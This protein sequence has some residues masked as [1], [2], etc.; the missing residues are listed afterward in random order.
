VSDWLDSQ[1]KS[2]GNFRKLLQ[3]RIKKANTRR[4]LTTEERGRLGD[5]LEH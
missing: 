1:K 5:V 3:E 4:E 2:S